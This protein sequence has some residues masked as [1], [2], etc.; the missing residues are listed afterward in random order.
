V[1][2]KGGD[3]T[4]ER[5][6]GAEEVERAGGEVVVDPARARPVDHRHPRARRGEPSG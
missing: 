4:G 3:Y 2:V 6:V 1:L 5:I